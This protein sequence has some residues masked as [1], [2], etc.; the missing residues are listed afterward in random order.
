LSQYAGEAIP[1]FSIIKDIFDFIDI[2]RDGII[3][4]NEWMQTFRSV[5]KYEVKSQKIIKYKRSK[6]KNI[7]TTCTF[8]RRP[9]TTASNS[10]LPKVRSFTKSK[11]QK[12]KINFAKWEVTMNYEHVIQAIGRNR[13]SIDIVFREMQEKGETLTYEKAKNVIEEILLQSGLKVK[14]E[15]WPMLLKFAEKNG[16]IDYKFL[17]E[18]YRGRKARM[19]ATIV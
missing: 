5:E 1:G 4:L 7:N 10:R 14:T 6:K 15:Y 18:I 17:L 2:R 8:A 12:K 19:E 11:T 13:K 3:D 9:V 16:I